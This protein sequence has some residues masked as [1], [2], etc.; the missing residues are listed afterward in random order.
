M[1]LLTSPSSP[2]TVHGRWMEDI[3]STSGLRAIQRRDQ[4]PVQFEATRDPLG[5]ALGTL[6]CKPEENYNDARNVAPDLIVH[7]GGLSWRSIG[8]GGYPTIHV[9]ENDIGPDD[10]N[11]DQ[12]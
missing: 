12:H 9:R 8:S 7:F 3:A 4:G 11:H 10:C 6:V 2:I 5:S 1:S